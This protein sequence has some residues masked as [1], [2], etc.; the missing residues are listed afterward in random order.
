MLQCLHLSPGEGVCCECQHLVD[1]TKIK[2]FL[3]IEIEAVKRA[4][5]A[6][7]AYGVGAAACV[8]IFGHDY[9]NEARK[10]LSTR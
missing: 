10:M 4:K 3:E 7:Y 2:I 9:G 6:E 1:D 8:S 5:N